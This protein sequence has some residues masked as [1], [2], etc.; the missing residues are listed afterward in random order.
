MNAA[1]YALV[2]QW[3]GLANRNYA[4]YAPAPR[5]CL[6]R[7]V[8]R[9]RS[10][11]ARAA[12]A[13]SAARAHRGRAAAQEA[14]RDRR[15]HVRGRARDAGR[16]V[17]LLAVRDRAL[18]L[19]GPWDAL[20]A[21]GAACVALAELAPVLLVLYYYRRIPRP[22]RRTSTRLF[23]LAGPRRGTAWRLAGSSS[24][25]R[26]SVLVC[27]NFCGACNERTPDRR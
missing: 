3:A 23:P 21:A 5:A 15:A 25:S 19:E 26:R 4:F 12:A 22:R 14:A 27:V 13:Y 17:A 18:P 24:P 11:S 2:M 8:P 10:S 1:T 7:A 6:C 16:S 9:P 20:V